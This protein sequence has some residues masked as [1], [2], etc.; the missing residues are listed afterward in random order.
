MAENV[1]RC[2]RE[3]GSETS[4]F[5]DDDDWEDVDQDVDQEPEDLGAEESEGGSAGEEEVFDGAVGGQEPPLLYE[6]DASSDDDDG[7]RPE[8]RPDRLWRLVPGNLE[9]W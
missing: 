2:S 9:N 8:N 1:D 4:S 6:P 7:E 3:S 5:R